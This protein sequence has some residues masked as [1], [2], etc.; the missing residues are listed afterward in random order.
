MKAAMLAT[1]LAI[2]SGSAAAASYAWFDRPDANDPNSHAAVSHDVYVRS[3][4]WAWGELRLDP[5]T[6]GGEALA[7][8]TRHARDGERR[9]DLVPWPSQDGCEPPRRARGK[10][11]MNLATA[12]AQAGG[13]FA[14]GFA[15]GKWA[16]RPPRVVR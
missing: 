14:G 9:R 7:P 13:G 2:G 12:P 11:S 1:A 16:A 3:F 4:G 5:D 15:D 10:I 6:T 8:P